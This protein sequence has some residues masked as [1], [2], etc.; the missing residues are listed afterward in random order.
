MRILEILPQVGIKRFQNELLSVSVVCEVMCMLGV[1]C[2]AS[3]W[4]VITIVTLLAEKTDPG[5]AVA[6]EPGRCSNS[7]PLRSTPYVE[8]GS[9][10][11]GT[12]GAGMTW[13]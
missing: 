1:L 8:M 3:A 4:E 11:K 12:C 13:L 5:K 9:P 6:E 10:E 2:S 7:G